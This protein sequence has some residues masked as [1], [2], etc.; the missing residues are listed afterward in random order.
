MDKDKD[1]A[2]ARS[3]KYSSPKDLGPYEP[4]QR[5]RSLVADTDIKIDPNVPPQRFGTSYR[6]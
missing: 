5:L 2:E 1:E 4:E 3:V 6:Q